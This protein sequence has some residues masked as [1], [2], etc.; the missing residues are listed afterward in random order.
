MTPGLRMEEVPIHPPV[1]EAGAWAAPWPAPPY[2]LACPLCPFSLWLSL[3][4]L[5][6]FVS[7]VLACSRPPALSRFLCLQLR[8]SPE[9]APRPSFQKREL[10]GPAGQVATGPCQL[11]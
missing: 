6:P 7:V 4:L 8:P 2:V 9:A 5:Y 3:R 1:S 10:R 11:W